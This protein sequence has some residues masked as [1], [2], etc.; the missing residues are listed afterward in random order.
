VSVGAETQANR[1]Q[2]PVDAARDHAL[3]DARAGIAL[4]EFGSYTCSYCHAAHAVMADLRDRFG[5]RIRYAFPHRPT[6]GDPDAPRAA[7][8]AE[9][10]RC[11]GGGPPRQRRRR[12]ASLPAPSRR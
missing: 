5:E 2:P 4:L 11:C 3:G 7:E 8:L 6:T 12:V 1:L 10:A 9:Y